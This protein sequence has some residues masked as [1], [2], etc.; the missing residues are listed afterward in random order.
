MHPSLHAVSHLLHVADIQACQPS[1]TMVQP[2]KP[3][4]CSVALL[5][6]ICSLSCPVCCKA[7]SIRAALKKHWRLFFEAVSLK[8]APK[9]AYPPPLAPMNS[10]R[11]RP[12]FQP[13]LRPPP[14]L[15]ISSAP[16]VRAVTTPHQAGEASS[17]SKAPQP[18]GQP[19]L[20]KNTQPLRPEATPKPRPAPV[21]PKVK[22]AELS[23][24]KCHI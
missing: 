2:C 7:C 11:P 13:N 4:H 19:A 15:P 24:T 5:N 6:V 9:I 3:S 21:T 1:E 20:P 23:E 16:L 18:R 14:H 17:L 12:A 10:A 8:Q 22:P